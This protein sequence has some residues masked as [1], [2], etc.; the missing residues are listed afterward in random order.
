M[1]FRGSV[2]VCGPEP[3]EKL[4][5]VVSDCVVRSCLLPMVRWL[6]VARQADSS[7][8]YASEEMIE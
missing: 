4:R 6:G 5:V 8:V 2:G 1:L 7:A 3:R